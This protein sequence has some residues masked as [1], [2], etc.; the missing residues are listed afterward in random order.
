MNGSIHSGPQKVF[1]SRVG[2]DPEHES[3]QQVPGL[4]MF[5]P[6]VG[7]RLRMFLDTGT[8]MQTSPVTR[9]AND[10]NAIVVETRNS[11]YRL[12]RAA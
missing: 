3:L 11:R 7:D 8:L 1:I 12:E 6:D 2:N 4:M 5:V 9:V 10:G